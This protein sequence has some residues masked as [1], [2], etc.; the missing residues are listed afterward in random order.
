MGKKLSRDSFFV[1]SRDM[2]WNRGTYFGIAGHV[3]CIAANFLE[4]RDIFW[5]RGT[6]I[7]KQAA[8]T[9]AS[10]VLRAASR[11]KACPKTTRTMTGR[12]LASTCHPPRRRRL[13][14][15]G[16]STITV[17]AGL[18]TRMTMDTLAVLLRT[19]EPS[20]VLTKEKLLRSRAQHCNLVSPNHS[21]AL[22]QIPDSPAPR[23]CSRCHPRT[24]CRVRGSF[25]SCMRIK[26]P[27]SV[28]SAPL[29]QA[30]SGFTDELCDGPVA[31]QFASQTDA[32][33]TQRVM[34]MAP[35]TGIVPVELPL[36]A[37]EVSVFARTILDGFEAAK[38]TQYS[39]IWTLPG[40][41]QV[42]AT[43]FRNYKRVHA[44][45]HL[46]NAQQRHTCILDIGDASAHQSSQLLLQLGLVM[47]SLHTVLLFCYKTFPSLRVAHCHLLRQDDCNARFQWHTD[48]TPGDFSAAV[49]HAMRKTFV[50]NLTHTRTSMQL[51]NRDPFVFGRPG[52]GALFDSSLEHRT[53]S[54]EKGTLKLTVFMYDPIVYGNGD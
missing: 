36:H 50:F 42:S 28:R 53:Y 40:G 14:S 45:A 27:F 12:H 30:L 52:C 13:W 39:C 47:P 18:T 22:L 15:S 6:N 2:F 1:A 29:A 17:V 19:G 32:S 3:C 54:A 33:S 41:G 24:L 11:C 5:N 26:H 23:R 16:M 38:R 44:K 9:A 21:H 49:A 10:R 8:A 4:S 7:Q 48:N 37:T 51:R 46:P 34:R 35:G 43:G 20:Q 31:R 25:S